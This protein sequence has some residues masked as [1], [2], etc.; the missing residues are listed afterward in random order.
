MATH[1]TV[2]VG[3]NGEALA[4]KGMRDGARADR[5][6]TE[7]TTK[8]AKTLRSRSLMM[9]PMVVKTSWA[10]TGQ[11]VTLQRSPERKKMAMATL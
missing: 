4:A 1:I 9:T 3:A 2:A 11:A 7:A 8:Q 10:S 5:L 6:D